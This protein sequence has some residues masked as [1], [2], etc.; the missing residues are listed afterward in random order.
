LGPR[1]IDWFRR[2]ELILS[3][4]LQKAARGDRPPRMYHRATVLAVDTDGGLLQNVAAS[5]GI[6]VRG[7]DGSARRY[8]AVVGPDNPRGSIKARLLTDGMDR[9]LDDDD[10]R[11]FWPL[12]PYDQIA[13]PIS[14]GEHVYVMFEGD[15][16]DHGL[17][18]SRVSGQDSANSF[19]G[20]DS[21]TAPSAPRSAMDSFE[22]NEP[23]YERTDSH[24][25]QAP[26]TPITD[27]FERD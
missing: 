7:S 26:S 25:A 24:A 17:W 15:G 6:T 20:S 12:F 23:E 22:P 21:Y 13:L 18:I 5:G 27:L 14:P 16:L 8:A 1:G 19:K 3:D 10:V 11:V 9:L 2:P 4:L